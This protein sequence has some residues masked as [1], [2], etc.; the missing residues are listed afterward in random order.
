MTDKRLQLM[1]KGI[2]R[3]SGATA[4][5]SKRWPSYKSTICEFTDFDEF[6]AWAICQPGVDCRDKA[7]NRYQ[8]DKDI[9]GGGG[10]IYSKNTCCFIPA[11]LNTLIISC[12]SARGEWPIGV[13]WNTRDQK[14]ASKIRSCGKR[15][16]LG[17]FDKALD[18]HAAWQDRKA[19]EIQLAV[20]WYQTQQGFNPLVAEALLDRANSIK[21]DRIH[22]RESVCQ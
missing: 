6:V 5:G 9:L 17:Y 18:A 13:S 2:N 10:K 22:G 12:A 19:D 8:L 15:V 21:Q 7:G 11:R 20:D 1:W 14:F 16:Y 4:E 3:R